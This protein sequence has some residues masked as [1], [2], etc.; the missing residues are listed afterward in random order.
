LPKTNE[1]SIEILTSSFGKLLDLL[2]DTLDLAK[3]E[4]GKMTPSFTNFNPI[5]ELSHAIRKI[6]KSTVPVY[7]TTDPS[8]PI[9]VYG[10]PHFFQRITSNLLSNAVKFTH[11]GYVRLIMSSDSDVW[12]KLE[13]EDTG[14]GMSEEDQQQFF[15]IFTMGDSSIRRPY[16]GIGVGLALCTKML[17]LLGGR[18][19]LESVVG[20]GSKFTVNFPFPSICLPYYPSTLKDKNYQILEITGNRNVSRVIIPHCKFY[21]MEVVYNPDQVCDRLAAIFIYPRQEQ[22]NKAKEIV[23]KFPGTKIVVTANKND[24]FEITDDMKVYIK[25]IPLPDLLGI[26]NEIAW[27]KRPTEQLVNLEPLRILLAEDNKT[28]Q[29]V[30]KKMF[31][32]LKINATIVEN[33]EEAINELEKSKY[34]ILFLDEFMPVLDGPSAAREIRKNEKH[35]QLTI[36]ALTASHG[37]DDEIICLSAGMNAFLTKPITIKMMRDV[38]TKCIQGQITAN[39]KMPL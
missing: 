3:I 9:L 17:S 18:M 32:K 22:I 8:L 16:G 35:N 20:K 27:N 13:V 21:N 26:F 37:K 25:P 34:D 4:Q 24:K 28:N 29:F 23:K 12:F 11:E 2:N 36:I 5:V 19:E 10:D 30:M 14:I 7:T 39:T 15:G 1:E 38:L 6:K 31:Q 33:G